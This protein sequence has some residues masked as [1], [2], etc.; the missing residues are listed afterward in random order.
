MPYF[1]EPNF[2]MHTIKRLPFSLLLVL[3]LILGA[4]GDV[5]DAPRAQTNTAGDVAQA[6]GEVLPIDTSRSEVSWKAAK[7]TRAHDG[8]FNAFDGTITVAENQIVGA[9]IGIDTRSIFSDTPRLTNHLKSDDFFDVEVHPDARFIANQFV[10]VDSAGATHLVTGNLTIRDTTNAVTFPAT[11]SFNG[12]TVRAEADFI[13]DRRDWGINY[14]GQADDLIE[15]NVRLILD[16]V[17]VP[18]SEI[19]A[20]PV[21][22]ESAE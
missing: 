2:Q 19:A 12:D 4:C 16:V 18:P 17:A 1:T 22:T 5:G 6:E 10:P 15:N 14:K 3:V 11:V 8:G 21:S 7:V 20:R 9:D 13:I